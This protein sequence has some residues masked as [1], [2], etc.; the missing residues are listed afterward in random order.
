MAECLSLTAHLQSQVDVLDTEAK[1]F[2][3]VQCTKEGVTCLR[4]QSLL[5]SRTDVCI[6]GS[7]ASIPW[8]SGVYAPLLY[9]G[10]CLSCAPL[11]FPFD[12]QCSVLLCPAPCE[13]LSW[14]QTI[15]LL[16][17]DKT[18]YM[19][20]TLL[21]QHCCVLQMVLH[22]FSTFWVEPRLSICACPPPC[23]FASHHVQ[24]Q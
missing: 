9:Q 24:Q 7:I 2:G 16:V 13:P 22:A 20:P 19:V 6:D 5:S 12:K 11:Y 14:G 3:G 21:Y 15:S 4:Q 23:G 8:T 17:G 1:S 18:S 10:D